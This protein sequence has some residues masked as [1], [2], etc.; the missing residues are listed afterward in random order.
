MAP[1]KLLLLSLVLFSFNNLFCHS[2]LVEDSTLGY[3][4]DISSY[5]MTAYPSYYGAVHGERGTIA[6]Q[7]NRFLLE[8]AAR[9]ARFRSSRKVVNVEDYGAQGGGT[10]D[11]EAFEEAWKEACSSSTSAVLV[12]PENKNYLLKPITFSGPCKSDVSLMPCKDAPTGGRGYAKNII[13][14]NFVMHEVKNPIII[15][16][17][18][19]DLKIPC[20]QQ[21][22]FLISLSL[23]LSGSLFLS[24]SIHLKYY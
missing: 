12:V 19:C 5:G 11:T 17:N 1:Q 6:Y 21:V 10:D 15:D 14:Q 4:D 20:K 9:V 23:S 2:R 22:Q 18:Y 16:Q 3:L 7:P 8:R 24:F 13:F